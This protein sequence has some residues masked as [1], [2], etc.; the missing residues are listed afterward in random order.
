MKEG[1]TVG[2]GSQCE[3]GGAT[4]MGVVKVKEGNYCEVGRKRSHCEQQAPLL[5]EEPV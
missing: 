5:G 2:R 1:A 4:V 3:K